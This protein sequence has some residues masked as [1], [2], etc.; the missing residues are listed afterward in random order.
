ML[1]IG[2]VSELSVADGFVSEDVDGANIESS[3]ASAPELAEG[4]FQKNINSIIAPIKITKDKSV[5]NHFS[6][7][8]KI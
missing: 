6:L 1:S 2:F 8:I 5:I 7:P 3:V 4:A